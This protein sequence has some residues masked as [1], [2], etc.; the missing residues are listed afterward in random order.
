MEKNKTAEERNVFIE[1]DILDFFADSVKYSFNKK[2][3]DTGRFPSQISINDFVNAIGENGIKRFGLLANSVYEHWGIN[4]L[5][6]MEDLIMKFFN[7]VGKR[8]NYTGFSDLR[9]IKRDFLLELS[10]SLNISIKVDYIDRKLL[11]RYAL[12]NGVEVN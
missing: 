7:A 12:I 2:Y 4:T 8:I 5:S 10:D 6:D 9:E 3:S 1:R 11:L